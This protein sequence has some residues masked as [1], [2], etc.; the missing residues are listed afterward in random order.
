MAG[1]HM[2]GVFTCGLLPIVTGKAGT[3]NRGVNGDEACLN[4]PG[5]SGC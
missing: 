1:R 2:G 5:N 4:R 3:G